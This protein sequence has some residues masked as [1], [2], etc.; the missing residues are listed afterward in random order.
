MSPAVVNSIPGWFGK[1]PALGDF[2]SRR[3]PESFLAPWDHWLQQALVASREALGERWLDIYLNAPI[4]RF[5]IAPGLLGQG[6]WAGVLTPSVDRV[7]R[8][9][10]L[11][12]AVALGAA[13]P[14]SLAQVMAARSWFDRIEALAL[15]VLNLTFSVEQLEEGLAGAAFPLSDMAPESDPAASYAGS[16]WWIGELDREYARLDFEALPS[17]GAYVSLL[18]IDES[19]AV[20]S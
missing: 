14:G 8:H 4:R 10:P 18:G 20:H 3:L 2:A 7:G 13:D 12:I 17:S 15:Q 9:F 1:L 16:V 6:G 11:T 19:S 5:W